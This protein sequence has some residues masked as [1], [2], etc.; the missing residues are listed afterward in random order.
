MWTAPVLL[1]VL[2]SVWFWDSAQGGAIG[3]LEDDLVTPGPGDDMVNPG[4]E[5]R[6]E[7]TD[8]TGELD[9]S[10][11]KAPLV[12][13]QP[14][15]EELPTSGTSDHDHKE[16]ESTTT[17]KAVTS[18]STDKKTT[19][20]NRDNAGGETQTTDKKDG[21]AVVTLVGIIIGVLLAIGFIGGIIIVV[22]RKISGR[23]SP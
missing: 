17:V 14:P 6:I 8:T 22:M 10:T 13:T 23:F 4:L 9:K 21:L 2:G 12:P 15:I 16:H 19:H 11:A 20:P 1:W 5:D 3:A 18:H 7:T